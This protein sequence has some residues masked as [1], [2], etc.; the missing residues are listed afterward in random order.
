MNTAQGSGLGPVFYTINASDLHPAYSS[1]ILF[2]YA[3]D[4]YLIVPAKYSAKCCE[5]VVCHPTA[6]RL[7]VGLPPPRLDVTRV[8]TITVLDV[9]FNSMLSFAPHVQNVASKATASLRTKDAKSPWLGRPG[10]MWG[11][12]VDPG[13][14]ADLCKLVMEWVCQGWGKG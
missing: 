6:D 13:G 7:K 4:T 9:T 3:D 8:E 2:K 5:M 1:N 12:A 10:I 14:S 11:D